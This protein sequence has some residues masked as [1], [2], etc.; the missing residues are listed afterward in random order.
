MNIVVFGASG[1]TGTKIV[2]QAL[3]VGQ[4]VT[5]FVR[6]P[7]KTSFQHPALTI[8]QGDALDVSTV[9]QAIA[10]QEAVISAL[11]PTRSS[12]PDNTTEAGVMETA[13]RNIV[14]AMHNHKIQRLISTT[15]AGVRDPEDQPKLMDHLMKGLLTLLAGAVLRDSAANVELI[16]ASDLDWTI[17]RFPRLVDGEHTGIY[18]VGYIGKDSG[19][20]IS[21]ADAADF[22]V[23]ELIEGKYIRRAPMV[24]Y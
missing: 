7:T 17:V 2:Q 21:R 18:R 9:D 13:A 24:S 15:G 14:A 10:G 16:R 4:H 11:G 19:T 20:R 23:N 6:N 5:A 3:D 22:I 1:R 12:M 8:F